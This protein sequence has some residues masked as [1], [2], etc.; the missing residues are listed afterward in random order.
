MPSRPSGRGGAY[1]LLLHCTEKTA[2]PDSARLW[3]EVFECAGMSLVARAAGCCGMSGT[4]GHESR[5]VAT[6][7]TIYA[8]SW[9]RI[10]NGD[11]EAQCPEL[12]ATG[13]SCRS[14]VARLGGR[15]LRHPVQVLV[16]HLRAAGTC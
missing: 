1:A 15:S 13:Y 7:R 10:V 5:N 2:E 3:R 11:P 14:Q 12:L 8:Q 4:Y 9:E 6:S 16:E